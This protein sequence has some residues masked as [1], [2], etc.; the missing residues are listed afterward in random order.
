MEPK[1]VFFTITFFLSLFSLHADDNLQTYI[2]QLHPHGM[3]NS[4]FNSRLEWHLSFLNQT[5]APEDGP[6]S[7]RL[8]YSYHSSME[9]FA[10][11]LSE[12]ELE[13]LQNM[14]NI[15]AV[16]P[17][18]R[19]QIHTTYSYKFLGLGTNGKGAWLSS[20]FGRG[21][22]IGV[23]DTG[24]WPESPSF[25]DDHMLR[26]PKNW[27]GICQEGQ[28]FNSSNC[29]R[30]L[31]G[32]R[33]YSKGHRA[34]SDIS[35]LKA[36]VEYL[37]PRDAFGHGTHTSS[38]AAGAS[39]PNAS[40]MGNGVGVARGMA[41]GAHVAMYKVC[42]FN[43]CYSSDILAAMDDAIRDGVDI[44][45]LS[46]GGFPVPLFDD[47]IAIGSYRAM[48]RGVM[49]ICAAGNNGP[50]P[51]SVANE[52]PWITTVGASTLDRR[53]P[54]EVHMGNGQILYGESMY[55]GNHLPNASKELEL[56]YITG[57]DKGSEFCFKGSLPRP[58]VLGKMVICDRGANGR[59]EK[60]QIVKEAGG[61]AMI[62]ANTA[63]NQEEDS[64]DVHVLPATLIGYAESVRLKSY[65]N[66]TRRPIARIQFGGTAIGKS[67]APTVALF[68][69]RGPSFFDRSILK[70]D[71]IAPGVNIIAA[72]PQNLGPS[73]LPE[74]SRR[75]NFNV[76]SGTSMACPHVSGI[77]AL[78]RSRHPVWSP[79][80]VKSAIM[81]TADVTDHYS[82][83]IMDGSKPAQVFA[84][85]SGHV[86]PE[87]ATDPGLVYDIRPSEYIIHLCTLGYSRS[88]I[89]TITHRN[90]SCHEI[91]AKNIGFSLNYPSISV[92][93]EP[94]R[95]GKKIK[96]RLTNVGFPNS[97]Y[98]VEV[99]APKGVAVKVRPQHL[100][101]NHIYQS[102]T[103]SIWF[104]SQKAKANPKMTF[105]QGHLTWM[106][107]QSSHYRVRSPI[108]VTWADMKQ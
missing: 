27:R 86:N 10:A 55:P 60:G 28:N 59:A 53:F 29:N 47:S 24:V 71:I 16:R 37:S 108:S 82:K 40:V 76:M 56:V 46:L 79:A 4:A 104:V 49:V 61:A 31:I 54:A 97:T 38:T 52:A 43:G 70:P 34:S 17:D 103:Y 11:R 9:G 19:L 62:L 25:S 3:T 68:S 100:T 106:H 66:S 48:E 107:S 67:R 30:K 99:V 50:I 26:V 14:Q 23:L 32:A 101:F 63:I 85:G 44:L 33:F 78:I 83:P 64:V 89:F 18:R 22:I 95:M 75:V 81:T 51:S 39:V 57:G 35:R 2:V 1:L 102:L 105:A 73:S 88:Q 13:T 90:V 80:A 91:M 5:I 69:S 45:S 93:F 21:T 20:G 74:D 77:A 42:W 87:R 94:G 41:S 65:I 36:P 84:I 98:S 8:L 15:I 92:I 6:P 7:S 96:R 58:S 12:I 72:W